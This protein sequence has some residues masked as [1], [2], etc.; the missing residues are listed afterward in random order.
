MAGKAK[1]GA[2]IALDGEKEFKSAISGINKDLTVLK[3]ALEK[4]KSEFEANGKS[5]EALNDK[6]VSYTHLLSLLKILK[7]FPN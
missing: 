4:N 5:I 1:I 3:S 2:G 7:L 6:S